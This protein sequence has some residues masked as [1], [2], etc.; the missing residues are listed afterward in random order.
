MMR[1]ITR[2][3]GQEVHERRSEGEQKLVCQEWSSRYQLETAGTFDMEESSMND[4]SCWLKKS[5]HRTGHAF[6]GVRL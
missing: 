1:M 3:I 4:G 2:R 6:S 5:R